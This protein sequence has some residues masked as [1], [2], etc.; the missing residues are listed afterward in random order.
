MRMKVNSVPVPNNGY[1]DWQ[2]T[3]WNEEP[4]PFV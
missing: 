2:S 3:G 4:Q 1:A